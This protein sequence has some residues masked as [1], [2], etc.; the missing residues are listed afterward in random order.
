[1]GDDI[2][3][4]DLEKELNL[5]DGVISLIDLRVYNLYGGDFGYSPDR[6]PL[7]ER[8]LGAGC[9]QTVDSPYKIPNGT[10]CFEIDL[11]AIDHVLYGDYNAMY[12]I[13]DK[14]DIQVRVKLK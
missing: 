2:F 13:Y 9:N 1:M 8:M 10:E 3:L 6:C 4:G 7:P 12:E 14:N 11:E 5:I